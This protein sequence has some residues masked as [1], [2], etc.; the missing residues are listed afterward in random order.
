PSH[1]QRRPEQRGSERQHPLLRP[2]LRRLDSTVLSPV[3]PRWMVT[4]VAVVLALA[5][6]LTGAATPASAL[7][8]RSGDTITV[9]A[10]ELIDDDLVVSGRS[11]RID[12]RV[13]G[14]VYAFAQSIT[15]GGVIEGDLIAG[16]AQVVL[17]GQVQ[18]DVRAA[19][20]TV[21]INGAVGRNVLSAAQL[22][23][24]GS[25]GRVGGNVIGA[26]NSATL[27]GDIAGTLTGAGDTIELQGAIGRNAEL[28]VESLTVGPNARVGGSLTYHSEQEVSVPSGTVAGIVQYVPV[29]RDRPE[30]SR[31]AERFNA[32]GNFLSLAWL[33]GS[34]I[35]GLVV[36]RL[37]PRFA[38]E[39]LGALETQLLPGL[40][41]GVVA[42]IGTLPV[43][44]LAGLTIVGIP[45]TLLLVAGY[46]SGLMVGWLLL[47]L[48]TGSILIGLVRR[49][50]PWHHSWA[51]LLGLVV[52]Y[53]ATRI[54]FLGALVT[55]VGLALGLGAFLVTLYRTWRRN[56]PAPEPSGDVPR[57]SPAPIAPAV[58]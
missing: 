8:R 25:G 22:L 27:S 50:R 2:L 57:V 35:V 28:G 11:V 9:G 12:G 43:A 19:G 24:L 17:L 18:G 3:P 30:H 31:P 42:L 7:E 55:F 29:E 45:I 6:A 44:V 54:P 48:A 51:F 53:V 26:A 34:A 58:A 16:G 15:V 39:F 4:L 41:I 46:F 13:R 52:L 36:L 47:A 23:Q 21:H 14:D 33:A 1:R 10:N 37:F 56:G 20:A 38:A 32:L 5:V 40:G 49:G